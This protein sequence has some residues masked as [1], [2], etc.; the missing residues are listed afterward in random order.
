MI[1]YYAYC[2]ICLVLYVYYVWITLVYLLLVVPHG[3]AYILRYMRYS[4]NYDTLRY[5]LCFISL[6]R[7]YYT[8]FIPHYCAVLAVDMDCII[9]MATGY[10]FFS[11]LR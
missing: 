8:S 7:I 9:S 10:L 3:I 6:V 2:I 5:I 11:W 1:V 4:N